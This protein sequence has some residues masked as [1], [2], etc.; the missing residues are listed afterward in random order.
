MNAED[1]FNSLE[2]GTVVVFKDRPTALFTVVTVHD[3]SKR[4]PLNVKT[5]NVEML[6][7]CCY[8]DNPWEMEFSVEVEP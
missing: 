6:N 7:W 1:K 5:C 2:P 3:Y 4:H 8:L